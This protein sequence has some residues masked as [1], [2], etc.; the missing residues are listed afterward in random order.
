MQARSNTS[1][2]VQQP[3]FGF[4]KWAILGLFIF[5]FVFSIQFLI[6]WIV[7]NIANDWIRTADL[8]YWKRPLYQLCHNQYLPRYVSICK[9][10]VK[11]VLQYIIRTPAT[12]VRLSQQFNQEMVGKCVFRVTRQ[13]GT[14][15]FETY[16]IFMK[17]PNMQY[18]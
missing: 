17:D 3:M 7:N 12:N 2:A 15:G 5:I 10:I 14:Y 6:H 11:Q 8:W 13:L 16:E 1:L 9:L 4:F 18:R